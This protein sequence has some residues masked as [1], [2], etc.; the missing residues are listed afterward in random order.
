MTAPQLVVGAAVVR[1]GRLLAARRAAS[2]DTAGGWELPGGKVEAGEREQEALVREV[3]EELGCRVRAVRR[4]GGEVL[5][6]PG[7]VLVAWLAE[8]VEGEPVPHEHDVLRWLAPEELDD[9]AWLAADMPFVEQLLEPLLDGEVL[10]G[11]VG[12]AARIGGTVRR[13]TGPWTPAV[14]ALLAHVRAR[15]LDGVPRVLGFD[16]RGREVLTYI[17]GRSIQVDSEVV[18]DDLLAQAVRWLR[19]L[20]EAV[21]DH[22][23]SGVRWRTTDRELAPGEIVCHHDVGAYNWV[24]QADRLVGVIDWDMAGPGR[25]LDDLAFMAW[26]SL[27]L[28]RPQPLEDTGRRLRLMAAEYGGIDPVAL[29]DAVD[30]R[31]TSAAERIDAGQR[32]GDPGMLNLQRVGEPARMLAGLDALRER[33]PAIRAALR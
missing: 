22:R 11:N 27:P 21:A 6:R 13:P 16:A 28:V 7:L 2:A 9:V 14:H 12:G 15:G 23:P 10:P 3:R 25:P 1:H 20:H 19:R 17:S 5:L 31:M 29:L 26:S 4:L 32:A 8:L 33:L 24:V 30:A 18:S